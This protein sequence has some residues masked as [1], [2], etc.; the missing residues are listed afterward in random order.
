[1]FF[2]SFSP[3]FVPLNVCDIVQATICD[4]AVLPEYQ[5]RGVGRKIVRK[6]M[7]VGAAG[8]HVAG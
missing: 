5:R 8:Y 3:R 1:M 4:V 6:L 7:Q 2:S